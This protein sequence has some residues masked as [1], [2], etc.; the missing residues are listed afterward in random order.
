MIGSG[1]CSRSSQD[2]TACETGGWRWSLVFGCLQLF[3]SQMPNLESAWWSSIIGA[4]MSVLYS[5]CALGLGAANGE[6]VSQQ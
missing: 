2:S 5:S 3:F 6:G 1:Y 4:V